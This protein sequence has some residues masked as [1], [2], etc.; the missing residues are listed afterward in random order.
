MKSRSRKGA[1]SDR[2][3]EYGEIERR[4]RF[5]RQRPEVE[6]KMNPLEVTRQKKKAFEVYESTHGLGD[7]ACVSV[8][9]LCRAFT[10]YR[11]YHF[12]GVHYSTKKWGETATAPLLD[13]T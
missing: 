12:C 11:S 13:R 5:H 1:E 3:A 4:Q 9:C 10:K 7:N 6:K 8:W 2:G